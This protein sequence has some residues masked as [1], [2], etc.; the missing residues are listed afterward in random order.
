M[1]IVCGSFIFLLLRLLLNLEKFKWHA[2]LLKGIFLHLISPISL[3][4]KIV[5]IHL[6][7]LI[8]DLSLRRDL[9]IFTLIVVVRNIGNIRNSIAS[10]HLIEL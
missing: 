6:I 2:S 3:R 5:V 10:I 9:V 8:F 7:S 1:A 4:W